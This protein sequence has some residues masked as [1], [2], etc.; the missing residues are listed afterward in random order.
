MRKVWALIA[1][2]AVALAMEVS[3]VGRCHAEEQLFL[4]D[5]PQYPLVSAFI[6]GRDDFRH[7]LDLDSCEVI[8]HDEDG[9]EIS[10][11]YIATSKQSDKDH[12]YIRRFRKNEE[13]GWELQFW[14]GHD[15]AWE[16]FIDPHDEDAIEQILEVKGI[17]NF[18]FPDY[19]LF[20]CAYQHLFDEPYE[21]DFDDDELRRSV[22]E[23]PRDGATWDIHHY[24]WDD[25]NYPCVRSH[26]SDG[27][28]YVDK[29]SVYVEMEDSSQCII[30]ILVYQTPQYHNNDT[31]ASS[32][33]L[34]RFLY[35]HKVKKMYAQW[36]GTSPK[37]T[38][39]PPPLESGWI[40]YR[41]RNI[42]RYAYALV[43]GDTFYKM[44]PEFDEH[45]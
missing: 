42:G 25:K 34:Y 27:A 5:D 29:S 41:V 44:V 13:S 9:F 19:Y 4:D 1:A 12:E 39:S 28:W 37:W 11:K 14:N 10:A 22:I 8:S 38:E 6:W 43:Y 16:T 3:N 20:K 18:R 17:A 33:S 45:R 31:M 7:Y 35:D 15:K 26:P 24:L 36:R 21:D 40:D 32:I 23:L 2:F 30:R